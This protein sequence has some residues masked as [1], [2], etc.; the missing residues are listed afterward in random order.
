MH[1]R[2]HGADGSG[3]DTFIMPGLR[4]ENA[5][6]EESAELATLFNNFPTLSREVTNL[7]DGIRTVTRASDP[8]VMAVL[9]SHATGMIARVEAADDPRI[10]IQSPTLDIFF[11]RGDAIRS[12][13]EVTD[14]GLVVVQTS[15]DPEV[16]AA[17]QLHAAEISDMAE[18][19][20][21]AV[22][23]MMMTRLRN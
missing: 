23:E 13:V 10:F 21:Q 19:G 4:G 17:L 22:H 18:R 7:P 12:D 5:S 14:A 16:V 8:A 20:M 9:V 6:P 11:V 15:D 2:M 1:N 3:H